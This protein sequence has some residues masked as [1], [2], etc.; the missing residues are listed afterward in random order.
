[1]KRFAFTLFAAIGAAAAYAAYHLRRARELTLRPFNEPIVAGTGGATPPMR[2]LIAGDSIA[3]GIGATSPDRT[4]GGRLAAF[5]AE[6]RVVEVR[7]EAVSGS[8]MADIA[9]RTLPEERQDLIVLIGGSNDL[10]QFRPVERF[11]EETRR[12]MERYAERPVAWSSSGRGACSTPARSR[13]RF[14]PSI[15]S[16]LGATP[17][18]CAKRR[19]ATQTPSTWTRRTPRAE[20]C[21]PPTARARTASTPTTLATPTGSKWSKPA[22]RSAAWCGTSDPRLLEKQRSG[23]ADD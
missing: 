5:L 22:S 21:H 2:V 9:G 12:A 18:S 6:T 3:A 17:R 23:R 1:M 16:R 15:A 13:G 7:N 14:E 19:R 10:F 8:T 20:S 11:A 4:V